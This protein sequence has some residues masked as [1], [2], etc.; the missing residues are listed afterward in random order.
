MSSVRDQFLRWE[1]I[2]R[3]DFPPADHPVVL[4]PPYQAFLGYRV[5]AEE[6]DDGRRHGFLSRLFAPGI[7]AREEEEV[8][9]LVPDAV[10]ERTLAEFFCHLPRE[11]HE[12]RNAFGQFLLS[13]EGLHDPVSMD[14][15]GTAEEVVM[16]W[17]CSEVEARAFVPA[18]S[19]YAPEVVLEEGT[20]LLTTRWSRD[21]DAFEYGVFQLVYLNAFLYQL[22]HPERDVL[23]GIAGALADLERPEVAVFQVLFSR[24]QAG[25]NQAM[26]EACFDA[27]GRKYPHLAECLT[28]AAR[29]KAREPLFAT[30]IRIAARAAT[31]QRSVDI[32][33]GLASA[34]APLNHLEGNQLSVMPVDDYDLEARQADLLRRQ[35]VR[36]GM[37]MTHSELL[38][39]V[40]LPGK[41]VKEPKWKRGF[42]KTRATP[43]LGAEGDV[44]LGTNTHRSISRKVHLSSNLRVRHLHVLG[45]PGSGKS[46]FLEHL[47]RQDL[48]AGRGLCVLDPH[49]D[50]VDTLLGAIPRS[51]REDTILFDPADA[52]H[53]VGFNILTAHSDQERTLLASDLVA[54]FARLSTSWGD[55]MTVVLRNAILA[56]LESSQGGTLVDLRRFLLDEPFRDRFLETV[57]DP[58]IGFFWEHGFKT[59]TGGKSIGPIVTRLETFLAPK[60]VRHVVAQRKNSLDFR[61]IMDGGKVLLV[62]L[63]HGSIGEENAHLLGSLI[64]SKFG[65]MAMARAAIESG[66]RRDFHL[67][68]DEFHA[69]MTPS[70]AEIITGARKY[71]LGLVLAHQHLGQLKRVDEVAGA[72]RSSVGTRVVF[73]VSHDAKD[74]A[75][76]FAH[77]EASDFQNLQ[78]GEAIVRVGRND[79]DFNLRVPWPER[80][81]VEA[82]RET[83]KEV[84]ARTRE[85]YAKPKADVEAEMLASM[86]SIVSRRVDKKTEASSQKS[87][88]VKAVATVSEEEGRKTGAPREIEPKQERS[89]KATPGRGGRDHKLLQERVKRIGERKGFRATL[90]KRVL[91]G[92]GSIDVVLER[93]DFR[94]AVEITVTT[95]VAH[96]IQNI[97]KCSNSGFGRV[98][99]LTEGDAKR[100]KIEKEIRGHFDAS[101]EYSV[102]VMTP[103]QLESWLPQVPVAEGGETKVRRGWKVRK[104][105]RGVPGEQRARDAEAIRRIAQ[106]LKPHD[107]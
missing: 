54:V 44:F 60:P 92:Q 13:L 85:V 76:D 94:V 2:G 46:S 99:L 72:V 18:F 104:R 40:H 101:D 21:A 96:E 55:Q 37:L 23:A 91:D 58:E 59:L 66:D 32:L 93:E 48:E 100:A 88:E 53:A 95:S 1:A 12:D 26:L 57:S 41:E 3:G 52:S 19:A 45:A 47:I 11:L 79:Q 67:Y 25:W 7:E 107:S 10:E 24:S 97:R 64:V 71:R 84:I 105:E 61:A 62:R 77:F 14:L 15:V 69:F 34:L 75:S 9:E 22:T 68:L 8:L 28:D 83:S 73:N 87:P 36:P 56:F 17:S 20:D 90:E 51:R 6:A 38:Q 103:E 39:L 78:T 106:A 89:T 102:K 70:M 31:F 65:Q 33:Q 42:Q 27:D 82:A 5:R 74:V 49:G 63:S 81:D 4:E 16:L 43:D 80:I 30:T 29:K 35:T 98:V 50:L 86:E